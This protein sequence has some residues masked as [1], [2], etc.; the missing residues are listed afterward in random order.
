MIRRPPRA[1][2]RGVVKECRSRWSPY[3]YD[4]RHRDLHSFPT[5]RSSDLGVAY[6]RS[7]FTVGAALVA[8]AA[9]EAHAG[10]SGTLCC[11]ASNDCRQAASDDQCEDWMTA[12]L[13]RI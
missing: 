10:P 3:H 11:V 2:E 5:R 12:A 1:K 7:I 8:L 6:H 4:T 9:P 13:A